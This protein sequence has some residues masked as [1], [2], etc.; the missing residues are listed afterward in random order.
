MEPSHWTREL[1]PETQRPPEPGERLL[2]I[3]LTVVFVLVLAALVA[4][5]AAVLESAQV[6]PQVAVVASWPGRSGGT[7]RKRAGGRPAVRRR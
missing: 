6:M 3:V 1:V 5:L 7:P 4:F 2:T